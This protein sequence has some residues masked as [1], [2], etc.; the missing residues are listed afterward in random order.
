M[1]KYMMKIYISKYSQITL[2]ETKA[3]F[4]ITRTEFK[5]KLYNF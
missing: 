5:I 4:Y 1:I 3:V 2:R